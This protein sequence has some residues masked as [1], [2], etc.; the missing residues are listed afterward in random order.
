MSLLALLGMTSVAPGAAGAAAGA[1]VASQAISYGLNA[2]AAS[3][4]W[5]RQKNMA[6]RSLTYFRQ[7]ARDAGFSPINMLMS[8][9]PSLQTGGIRAPQASPAQSQIKGTQL[10][11]LQSQVAANE[12]N[13]RALDAQAERSGAAARYDD[14]RTRKTGAEIPPLQAVADRFSQMDPAEKRRIAN[15]YIRNNYRFPK[16]F[17]TNSTNLLLEAMRDTGVSPEQAIEKF[18]KLVTEALFGKPDAPPDRTGTPTQKLANLQTVF[19]LTQRMANDPR[20]PIEERARLKKELATIRRL[21]AAERAA[22]L[23]QMR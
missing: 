13:A 17:I 4:A 20:L 22:Y 5:D 1:D 14:A 7:N 15:D 8:G 2:K 12:A 10:A 16:D 18:A 6:T 23:R 3:T 21:V 11:L 19:E 9:Q